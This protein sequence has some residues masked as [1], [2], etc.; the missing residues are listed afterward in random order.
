M[1]AAVSRFFDLEARGSTVARELRGAV[2][3]FLTMS[4]I[5]IVNP[6]ILM[7][8]GVPRDAA[9]ACTA[10]AAGVCCILMGLYAN[11]PVAL[12][13]GMG[14]NALIASQ[15]KLG[16][17]GSWQTAMGLIVLDGTIMML[18][19]LCGLREAMLNAIPRDMRRAIAGGIGLFIAFIG[20]VNARI[21]VKDPSAASPPVTSGSLSTPETWIAV[22]GLLFT[23]LLLVRRMK[24]ALVLGILLCTALALVVGLSKWPERFEPPSFAN[25]LQADVIGALDLKLVPVLCAF[26][27]VNFFDAL[28]TVTALSEQANLHDEKGQ[29][30]GLHNV[31]LAESASA[32]I[33]GFFGVSSVTAY[34]ESA[35]GVAEGA[36][37]GLHTVV[38]GLLFLLAILL[39]PLAQLVP[40]A[41][42]APA[43]ILV[44]FLMTGE[45]AHIDFTKLETSIPAFVTL[46][47]VPFTYS[48][49]HGV[50]YGFITHVGIMLFWGRFREVH[51]LMYGA[52]AVFAGYF[53]FGHH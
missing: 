25:A 43:M 29:I 42:T 20:V 24:G 13:S 27:L 26:V 3:T 30:P 8:A 32:S 28:G 23:A 53:I 15:V 14:L 33:G 17:I 11:F 2:A 31:L 52:A 35:A 9:V 34:I 22:V 1:W 21:A 16:V 19:V 48:I 10:A 44:G 47:T 38:V 5:V 50:G 40:L 46:I 4:Y 45:L 18:L 37:T 41:A 39:A 12:A 7:D 49:A 51:P 36:R 6:L